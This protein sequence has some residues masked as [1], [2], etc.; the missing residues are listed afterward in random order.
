MAEGFSL[1]RQAVV[2]AVL[3]SGLYGMALFGAGLH[4]G[5][6]PPG[7]LLAEAARA[8]LAVAGMVG[9]IFAGLLAL[10]WQMRRFHARPMLGMGL[11]ILVFVAPLFA[12][13]AIMPVFCTLPVS[14][15]ML[16]LGYGGLCLALAGLIAALV[17][18]RT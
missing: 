17:P 3:A 9:P 15:Q 13:V 5:A 1:M 8:P 6:T 18:L 12:S 7:G 14:A 4:C 16:A 10:M 11:T 2:P